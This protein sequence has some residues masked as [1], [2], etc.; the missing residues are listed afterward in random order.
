[1]NAHLGDSEFS[2]ANWAKAVKSGN[3]FMSS[4]P[5][6]LFEVDGRAGQ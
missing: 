3:T 5:L 6:L 1:M 2:F 4:G